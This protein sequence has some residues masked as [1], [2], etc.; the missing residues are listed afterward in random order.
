M[1]EY[2][3]YK[4]ESIKIGTCENMYYLRADQRAKITGY[5]FAS[6]LGE[7]RFRF[8]FPDEDNIEP[9]AFE[10]YDR[11]FRIPGGWTIPADFDHDGTV[12]FTSPIGYVLS[13]RCPESVDGPRGLGAIDVDGVNVHRNGF[14]GGYVVRQQKYVD[15]E[16]WTVVACKSCGCAWRLPRETAATVA[17]AFLD[18]SERQEWRRSPS[19][20]DEAAGRWGGSCNYGN[21]YAHDEQGRNEF[22]TMAAR[23]LAGY[24][25]KVPA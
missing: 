3:K 1:G 17:E 20:W 5:D 24:T 9:G 23:I 7:I 18:E 6:C 2:A 12:Q 13:I 21:E 25:E 11:G 4:G 15:G 14:R 16:W 10:D 8:P 22:R 19:D